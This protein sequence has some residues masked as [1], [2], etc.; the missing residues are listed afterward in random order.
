MTTST[1]Y[2]IY[3]RKSTEGDDR[4]ARSIPDQLAELRELATK[5]GLQIVEELVESKSA[6]TPGRAIFNR[7]LDRINDDEASGILAW[8]P[9]RLARNSVD[10]GRLIWLLDTNKLVD[11]K[12]AT[13]WFEPTSQGK[14]VLTFAFGMSKYYVDRLSEDVTRGMRHKAKAGIWPTGAPTGYLNEPRSRTVVIDPIKAPLVKRAF[15]LYATGNYSLCR[16]TATMNALG[17]TS[18]RNRPL[19]NSSY[20]YLLKNS[21]YYGLFRYVGEVYEGTHQPLITKQL[22]DDVQEVMTRKGKPRRS[23]RRERLYNGT[24]VCSHCGCAMTTETQ[25]GHNYVRCTKKRGPCPQPYVREERLS[26]NI[27]AILQRSAL[28]D[29]QAASMLEQLEYERESLASARTS[30]VTELNAHLTAIALKLE[31]LTDGYLNDALTLNELQEAKGKLFNNK[32][33]IAAELATLTDN[34]V[35]PLEPMAR[36]IKAA[37]DN[38]LLANSHNLTLQLTKFKQI[39]SNLRVC[40]G[41]VEWEPRGPWKHV[42]NAGYFATEPNTTSPQNALVT[43]KT[44]PFPTESTAP[45]DARSLLT[46]ILAFFKDN[47]TWV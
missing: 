23:P 31:R 12:F 32:R 26:E 10:G 45:H 15:R 3:A 28:S 9:D 46:T 11:L 8:H 41:T 16:L 5:Q 34:S 21:F 44:P 29:D 19:S 17:L 35:A 43:L 13:Y 20:Q 4:Q 39:G 47:P 7:M 37:N 36:F 2:F 30:R 1:R 25:K 22:F 33:S 38:V 18:T 40:R 27:A 42:V 6:K 14:L 24:F